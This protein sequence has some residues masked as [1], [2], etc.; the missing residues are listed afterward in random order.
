MVCHCSMLANDPSV[1]PEKKC[2]SLGK[3]RPYAKLRAIHPPSLCAQVLTLAAT[4]RGSFPSLKVVCQPTSGQKEDAIIDP[5]LGSW[6]SVTS[7]LSDCNPAKHPRTWDS[8]GS[9]TWDPGWLFGGA[10]PFSRVARRGRKLG[11]HTSMYNSRW[12][13]TNKDW[14]KDCQVEYARSQSSMMGYLELS[15]KMHE[16]LWPK[17]KIEISHVHDSKVR[18]KSFTFCTKTTWKPISIYVSEISTGK[19]LDLKQL[20]VLSTDQCHTVASQ[21]PLATH[22]NEFSRRIS[23][24]IGKA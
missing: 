1:Q 23:V 8:W 11:C 20:K 5:D 24:R 13:S 14:L 7:R 18:F 9:I 4:R 12:L 10:L 19:T 6:P 3:R 16:Y 21:L 17:H 22:Q 2:T 15:V